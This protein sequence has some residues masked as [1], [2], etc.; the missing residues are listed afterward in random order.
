MLIPAKNLVTDWEFMIRVVG[1]S[2]LLWFLFSMA[3]RRS[4]QGVPFKVVVLDDGDEL[5]N[6]YSKTLGREKQLDA[7]LTQL[8]E[9]DEKQLTMDD[10]LNE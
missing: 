3:E 4:S 1:F 10:I 5:S 6:K 9:A 2:G 7:I 8:N